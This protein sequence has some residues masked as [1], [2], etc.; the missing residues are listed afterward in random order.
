MSGRSGFRKTNRRQGPPRPL[1]ERL[2]EANHKNYRQVTERVQL[3]CR[4]PVQIAGLVHLGQHTSLLYDVDVLKDGGVKGYSDTVEHG[5]E[6]MAAFINS[7]TRYNKG[8]N[9]EVLVSV[10]RDGFPDEQR[11]LSIKGGLVA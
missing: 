11:C 8:M 9:T 10:I 1:I 6:G 7:Y 2:H 5:I 3:Y 4:L